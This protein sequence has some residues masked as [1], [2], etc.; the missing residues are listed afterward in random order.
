MS[1]QHQEVDATE[2][3]VNDCPP[4]QEYWAAYD[5]LD[6]LPKSDWDRADRMIISTAMG[7][8]WRKANEVKK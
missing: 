4:E 5:M 2:D 6:L 7:V 3:F 1:V 8:L